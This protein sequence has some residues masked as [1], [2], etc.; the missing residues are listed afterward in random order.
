[1]LTWALPVI[2][3]RLT[4]IIIVLFV[5]AFDFKLYGWGLN[6]CMDNKNS[7][8]NVRQSV[9]CCLKIGKAICDD[10]RRL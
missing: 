10:F 8:Q 6:K 3:F 9:I 5:K 1:M 4:M 7:H 2:N